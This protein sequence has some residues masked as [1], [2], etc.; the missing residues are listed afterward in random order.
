MW[1][2]VKQTCGGLGLKERI[3]AGNCFLKVGRT[4]AK[5]ELGQGVEVV[6]NPE[7]KDICSDS[8]EER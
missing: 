6:W 7:K 8:R 4:Y 1:V 5:L 3:E 2:K